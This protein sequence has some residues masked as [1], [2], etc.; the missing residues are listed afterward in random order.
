MFVWFILKDSTD[1]T[2]NSGLV[3]RSGIK[4]PSY[5]VVRE[6]GEGDRRP[7]AGDRR[8]A[9]RRR[10]GSTSRSSPTATRSAR[11]VGITYGVYDGK[12]IVAVGQPVG[13]IAADQTVSFVAQVQAA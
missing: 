10:S 9:S 5:A 2:W 3:A 1:K 6:G 4:K 8:R 13:R 11:R 12:K 7:G